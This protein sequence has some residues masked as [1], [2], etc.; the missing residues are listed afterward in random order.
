MYELKAGHSHPNHHIHKSY[1][2]DGDMWE[3]PKEV[4]DIDCSEFNGLI[5][6]EEAVSPLLAEDSSSP[7]TSAVLSPIAWGN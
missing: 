4:E 6:H 5:T 2:L 1:S 3:D 7:F